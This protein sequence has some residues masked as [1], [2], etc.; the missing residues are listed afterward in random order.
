MKISGKRIGLIVGLLIFSALIFLP[1][2]EGLSHQAMRAAA[3]ALLMTSLWVSEAIPIAATALLPLALFP[4]LGILDAETTAANYGHNYVLMLL[5]GFII[6]KAI[7]VH[8]LHRRIALS[9]MNL[10]GSSRRMLLLS[11]MVASALL[12]MW[13]ANVAVALLMLPIAMAI[14]SR[15]NEASGHN[16]DFGIALMLA[17]AYACS[18][19]GTGTLI[20]T[21][22]NMVFAGMVQKLYPDAPEIPFFQWMLLGVPLIVIFLPL[23]WFYLVRYFKIKGKFEGGKEIVEKELKGLGTMKP[24]EKMVLGIFIFTA[25]AWVFRRDI[26]VDDFVL[27][28]WASLLGVSDW[29][30]DSTVAVFSCLL[31]FFLPDKSESGKRLITW[32]QAEAIPWGTVMI[33]GGGYAIAES[34]G[35]TGLAAWLGTE[36]Q[37]IANWSP[38]L[39]LL[40]VITLMTFL[41]EINSNTATANIFLPVLATMA[42]SSGTHP[43]MLMIPATIACSFAFMLPS[44]TGT[45]TVIFGSELVTIPQM[46]RAGF[47]LNLISILLLT[48][49][50]YLVAVPVF[51]MGGAVPAWAK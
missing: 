9:I 29:V 39:V 44:G 8:H 23:I 16:K 43:Y 47:W 34:F 25:L 26:V 45:N 41:T 24:A 20:G 13:I 6:S 38:L 2:P 17:I 51:D 33:V 14:I 12:S 27:P 1:T 46:A 49:V 35:T 48:I 42:V 5:A 40:S 19:G 18:I 36:L 4:L 3:V 31:L 22:P 50:L 30:H 21:P 28:G 11:F 10:I 32:K 37:F 15:E 7:E